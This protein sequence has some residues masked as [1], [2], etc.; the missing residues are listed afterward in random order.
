MMVADP[1]AQLLAVLI[2][3]CGFGLLARR[4][5]TPQITLLRVQ[6][7]ALAAAAGWA[8]YQQSAPQLLLAALIILALQGLLLPAVLRRIARQ[9]APPPAVDPV[10]LAAYA[11]P[12][13]VLLF[14]LALLLAPFALAVPFAV[15][16][17]GLLAA[18][19]RREALAQV[20]GLFAAEAGLM[21]AAIGLPG[22]PLV[23]F[24]ALGALALPAAVL[25]GIVL[26]RPCGDLGS[27]S[28]STQEA[29][30]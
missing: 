16:L 17:L 7:C 30:H 20:I 27:L 2:L 1:L 23:A 26:L 19:L 10:P 18:A 9:I 13:G 25:A 29:G 24:L 21:L 3:L 8:T 4:R 5:L 11:L 6:A 14:V 28:T 15:I 12:L 22:L